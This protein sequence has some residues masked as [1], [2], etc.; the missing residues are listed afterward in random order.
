LRI[1]K[2]FEELQTM[3]TKFDKAEILYISRR[4][5]QKADALSKLVIVGD[6]DKDRSVIVLE[7]PRPS[8]DVEYVE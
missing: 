6:L 5:I 7:V 4:Q 3:C 2:Y 1:R 8:V